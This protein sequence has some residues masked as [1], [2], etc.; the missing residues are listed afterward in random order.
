MHT[1]RTASRVLSPQRA[2][3]SLPGLRMAY[4]DAGAGPPV[5]LLHGYP[6]DGSLWSAQV[7]G[8][9]HLA[10]CV[11]PDLRGFGGTERDGPWTI[12]QYA[13]DVAALLDY[14]GVGRAVIAGLSMGGYVAM[15]VWRRHPQRVRGLVFLDTRMEADDE[16]ARWRRDQSIVQL[17]AVG[18]PDVVE[19]Q[20]PSLL[21]T[22]TWRQRPDVVARMRR[23]MHAQSA[24]GMIGALQAMRD[25]PDAT[26]TI[27]SISVPSTIV[28]GAEDS[29]TPL[30]VAKAMFN[31][32][33]VE[34]APRLEIVAGAGH[35]CCVERPAAVTHLLG[36]VLSVL[37]TRA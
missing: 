6:F 26:D 22:H 17:G 37:D 1:L 27:R 5:V 23:M 11:V 19:A 7:Q 16:A 30:P 15:A 21:G 29:V 8:L 28:V 9:S 32:L 2:V 3:A 10:R 24:H 35:V 36:D 14:L 33:P 13:D 4:T 18:V 12:D 25:R 20:L 34:S 31:A